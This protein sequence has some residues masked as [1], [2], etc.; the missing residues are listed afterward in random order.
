MPVW[1][2][3]MREIVSSAGLYFLGALIAVLTLRLVV[4]YSGAYLS[5]INVRAEC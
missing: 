2:I 1:P 4:H 3:A 5:V